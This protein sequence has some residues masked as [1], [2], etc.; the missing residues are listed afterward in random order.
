MKLPK[1]DGRLV[2]KLSIILAVG[3]LTFMFAVVSITSV[4]FLLHGHVEVR[5]LILSLLISLGLIISL[6][7]KFGYVL[8]IV[9]SILFLILLGTSVYASSITLDSTY[10]GNSYHKTAIGEMKNGW[11]PI[12]QH[13]NDFNDSPQNP[14]KLADVK[15]VPRANDYLWVDTYP[16]TTWIFAANIY[17]LTG[18]IESGKAVNV[19]PLMIVFLLAF[20]YLYK[21]LRPAK[22]LLISALLAFNPV[23]IEQIAGYFN[24]GA[25]GNVLI[26][27][28]I[29]FTIFIDKK[30]KII[31]ERLLLFTIGVT[32]VLLINIKFTGL[33]YS[34]I[35][36]ACYWI[37]IALKKEWKRLQKLTL[38]GAVALIFGLFVVGASSYVKNTREYGN[39]LFPLAGNGKRDIMTSN[40]PA[41]YAKRSGLEN[42]ISA[43]MSRTDNIL[44][45]YSLQGDLPKLKVPFL[46]YPEELQQLSSS[47]DIRQGGYGVWFS[48]I[49][50]VALIVGIYLL[51][52]FKSAGLDNLALF[53]LPI[54][55]VLITIVCF[56]TSWWARYLPQ[57]YVVPIIVLIALMLT[58][59]KILTNII[60]FMVLFN[61]V[62]LI[63]LVGAYQAKYTATFNKNMAGLI[64]CGKNPLHMQAQGAMTGAL[65]N[66]YDRCSNV[67][68]M[69]GPSVN[70][71]DPHVAIRVFTDVYRVLP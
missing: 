19:L 14:H 20:G 8:Q 3:L 41:S 30:Q 33:A 24:D 9:T 52:R 66:I 18:N 42:F 51:W 71:N 50:I 53:L 23:A 35:V 61:I 48:G 22:S 7:R 68:P 62:L 64:T 26:A 36:A 43:N 44:L 37:F 29:L 70:I 60:S 15:G 63:S 47:P 2:A 38:L 59:H 39:P 12:Y 25:M 54:L 49:L 17:R 21:R 46:I 27:L 28:L 67:I 31:S 55:T 57:L 65:Y 32:L 6:T 34:A 4:A 13:V 69:T 56:N 16:K 40:E 1:I 10:D 58:K 45:S 11:N 5:Y